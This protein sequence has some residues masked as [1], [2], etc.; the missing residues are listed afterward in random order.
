MNFLDRF[1]KIMRHSSKS[2]DESLLLDR[3]HRANLTDGLTAPGTLLM[4][5]PAQSFATENAAVLEQ[6]QDFCFLKNSQTGLFSIWAAA[7]ETPLFKSTNWAAAYRTWLDLLQI[8]RSQRSPQT[9][10][11]QSPEALHDWVH[12]HRNDPCF[13][14]LIYS[15]DRSLGGVLHY[16]VQISEAI[17]LR[18]TTGSTPEGILTLEKVGRRQHRVAKWIEP[19]PQAVIAA[20][21]RCA[22]DIF[23]QQWVYSLNQFNSEH[24]AKLMV[25]GHC[26][27]DQVDEI[28]AYYQQTAISEDPRMALPEILTLNLDAQEI[29]NT[30]LEAIQLEYFTP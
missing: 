29:L 3:Q 9:L 1:S 11:I 27:C 20:T 17:A 8:Q 5:A 12:R 28:L 23:H 25:T 19:Q 21:L 26:C 2:E 6:T 22:I 24:W 15:R 30:A 7:A 14:Q 18:W 10:E 16:A 13:G 4:H